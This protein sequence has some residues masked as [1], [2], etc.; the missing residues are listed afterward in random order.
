V[1]YQ[2]HDRPVLH[3]LIQPSETSSSNY[4]RLSQRSRETRVR[5]C[6]WILPTSTYRARR[7]LLRAVNLRHGT[8]CFTSPPKEGVLRLLS[9]L[10]SIVLYRVWTRDLGSSGKHANHYTTVGDSWNVILGELHWNFSTHSN[11]S[12]YWTTITGTSHGDLHVFMR[13]EVTRWE[14][15]MLPPL[16][17]FAMHYLV[18]LWLPW[19]PRTPQ[20]SW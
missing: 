9:P 19:L 2:L 4:Q 7:V 16:P 11:F 6:R 15:P 10:K 8:D 12:E 3:T 14:I 18:I 13:V 1:G 17:L 20:T 5:N